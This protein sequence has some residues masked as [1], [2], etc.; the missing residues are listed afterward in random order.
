MRSEDQTRI[1]AAIARLDGTGDAVPTDA[2]R[3]AIAMLLRGPS[4][5]DAEVLLMRRAHRDGDRWSGQIAMPGGHE[6]DFDESL[7]HTARRE[8]REEVGVDPG[9]LVLGAL[10]PVQARAR[11]ARLPLFCFPFVFHHADPAEP[12][13]G[14]EADEAFWMPLAPALRGDLD[15]VHRYDHEGVIHKLP[16]WEFEGRVVWGMTFG[17]LSRFVGALD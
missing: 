3:A 8:S 13:P 12:E 4:L 14:P 15:T 5:A 16:A 17:I 11:G 2:R 6:E 1:E 9:E 10:P 7:V